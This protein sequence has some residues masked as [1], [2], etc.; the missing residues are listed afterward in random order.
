MDRVQFYKEVGIDNHSS[1]LVSILENYPDC[2][3]Y[4]LC[5]KFIDVGLN[6][7]KRMNND[8][9]IG[10]SFQPNDMETARD[11]AIAFIDRFKIVDIDEFL[12]ILKLYY[13]R[14]ADPRDSRKRSAAIMNEPYTLGKLFSFSVLPDE[15]FEMI[16]KEIKESIQGKST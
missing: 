11:T 8:G 3:F 15:I 12:R 2:E 16:A 5:Q 13:P 10:A 4:E 6:A 7:P 14:A 1:E 9:T